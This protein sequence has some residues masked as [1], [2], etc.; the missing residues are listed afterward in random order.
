VA[1]ADHGARRTRNTSM[2]SARPLSPWPTVRTKPMLPRWPFGVNF[3]VADKPDR[4]Q[5]AFHLSNR[6]QWNGCE[7]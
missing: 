6:P 1:R 5:P 2:G 4:M 7:F 3:R